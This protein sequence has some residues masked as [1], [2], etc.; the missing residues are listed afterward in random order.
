MRNENNKIIV[1]NYQ[2]VSTSVVNETT[3]MANLLLNKDK[4]KSGIEAKGYETHTLKENFSTLFQEKPPNDT[5]D[6]ILGTLIKEYY[7]CHGEVLYKKDTG[8][9]KDIYHIATHTTGYDEASTKRAFCVDALKT[10]AILGNVGLIAN[11]ENDYGLTLNDK[12]K[13]DV[14]IKNYVGSVENYMAADTYGDKSAKTVSK[15]MAKFSKSLYKKISNYCIKSTMSDSEK[16]ECISALVE[17]VNVNFQPSA[18]Y[19]HVEHDKA[20]ITFAQHYMSSMNE[21]QKNL[22]SNLYVCMEMQGTKVRLN[23]GGEKFTQLDKNQRMLVKQVYESMNDSQRKVFFQGMKDDK[24]KMLG[25]KYVA[26]LRGVATSARNPYVLS[27]LK[28]EENKTHCI[29]E[30]TASAAIQGPCG[31]SILKQKMDAFFPKASNGAINSEDKR[32]KI[33]INLRYQGTY[34]KSAFINTVGSLVNKSVKDQRNTYLAQEKLFSE[35]KKSIKDENGVTIALGSIPY[36]QKVSMTVKHMPVRL[37]DVLTVLREA[38]EKEKGKTKT[39]DKSKIKKLDA[40]LQS[41]D[42]IQKMSLT[43]E[44]HSEGPS[45]KIIEN[46][47]YSERIAID[48]TLASVAEGLKDYI[49]IQIDRGCAQ[50]KDR[51]PAIM[52]YQLLEKVKGE[53]QNP[54]LEQIEK[55]FA[56]TCNEV[57]GNVNGGVPGASGSKA[58]QVAQEISKESKTY[59]TYIVKGASGLSEVDKACRIGNAFKPF[60]PAY[61]KSLR[62]AVDVQNEHKNNTFISSAQAKA[63]NKPSI[64]LD[65]LKNIFDKIY[66][67]VF[68]DKNPASGLEVNL[69]IPKNGAGN[70][71]DDIPKRD[72]LAVTN[73]RPTPGENT[74]TSKESE[75]MKQ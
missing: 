46:R 24:D 67:A 7:A 74:C 8:N 1:D 62:K 12:D 50:C 51:G 5:Y 17:K 75:G 44:N 54:S 63:N 60:K 52:N 39:D 66:N 68:G 65:T 2:D 30:F 13:I 57:G 45:R 48:Q 28:T 26:S 42:S 71:A 47:T 35:N 38:I 6:Q 11:K 69:T 64:F 41:I 9:Q 73:R 4:D 36:G 55:L 31:E 25:G 33:Y 16:Y 23:S 61:E 29:G 34:S 58:S 15:D 56:S 10:A 22:L 3:A 19:K 49:N 40:A 72:N 18:I 21:E 53:L 32:N 70:D 59:S 43:T 27:A 14:A 20:M 37:D